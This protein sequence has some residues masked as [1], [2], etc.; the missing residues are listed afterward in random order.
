MR[1]PVAITCAVLLCGVGGFGQTT[2]TCDQTLTAPLHARSLLG[3]ESRP[4]GL[5]IVGTDEETIRVTCDARNGDNANASRIRLRFSPNA[6]GGKLKIEGEHLRHNHGAQI[7]IEVPK[8][9]SLMVR[10]FAGEIKV[11]QVSGDKDITVGAGQITIDNHNWNYRSVDA[12]VSIGQVNAPMYDANKG[13]FFR[14]V[15]KSTQ[16]GE[17]RLHA[18]VT[19]GQIDLK[20]KRTEPGSTPKPD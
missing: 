17:Y 7:R 5:E 3:I 1:F 14:S 18:H 4:A 16:G 2:A 9:T 6:T 15:S 10:M 13:G 8:R 19:T 12:S 11:E 20:G